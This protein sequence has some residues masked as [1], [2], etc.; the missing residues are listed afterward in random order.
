MLPCHFSRAVFFFRTVLCLISALSPCCK[1]GPPFRVNPLSGVPAFSLHSCFRRNAPSGRA[2]PI[3]RSINDTDKPPCHCRKTHVIVLKPVSLS[4]F[5]LRL[6][7]K[8]VS[9]S[10]CSR[11]KRLFLQVFNSLNKINLPFRL[12]MYNFF[13]KVGFFHKNNKKIKKNVQKNAFS[14]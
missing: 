13:R 14:S 7:K 1:R 6:P 5:S 9:I 10:V 12:F 11:Q 2:P 8:S 4:Y 3:G